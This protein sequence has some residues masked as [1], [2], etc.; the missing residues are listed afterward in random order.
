MKGKLTY[1]TLFTKEAT[2]KSQ[3]QRNTFP[4]THKKKTFVHTRTQV[5]KDIHI[6]T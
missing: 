6:Y 1:K 2:R 5:H 4:N 3:A